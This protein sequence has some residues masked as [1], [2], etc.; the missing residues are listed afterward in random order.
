MPL[1]RNDWRGDHGIRYRS[2]LVPE[3]HDL[4][5]AIPFASEDSTALGSKKPVI[6]FPEVLD[7][8]ETESGVDVVMWGGSGNGWDSEKSDLELS[9]FMQKEGNV[10]EDG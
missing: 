5:D 4:P 10:S 1:A 8:Q 6:S 9:A 7:Q 3:I 2:Y